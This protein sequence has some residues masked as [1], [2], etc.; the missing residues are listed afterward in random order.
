VRSFF[1]SSSTSPTTTTRT[2]T[3]ILR[4]HQ[5][6]LTAIPTRYTE[7]RTPS[8]TPTRSTKNH[9]QQRH[10]ERSSLNDTVQEPDDNDSFQPTKI[11]K[12]HKSQQRK[13]KSLFI[14]SSNYSLNESLQSSSFSP[15]NT[16]SRKTNSKPRYSKIMTP[17]R[18]RR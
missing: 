16:I 17:K 4:L 10:I 13:F 12:R 11:T 14:L 7:K 9:S 6:R 8:T 2:Q 5:S 1:L 18:R 15:D 3:T